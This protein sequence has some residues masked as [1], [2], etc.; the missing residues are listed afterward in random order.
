MRCPI[1]RTQASRVRMSRRLLI[2]IRKNRIWMTY[3]WN[4]VIQ[5]QEKTSLCTV[6]LCSIFSSNDSKIG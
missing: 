6:Y 3:I 5:V 4:K 2:K 1:P